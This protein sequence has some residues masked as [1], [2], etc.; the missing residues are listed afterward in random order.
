MLT[1]CVTGRKGNC[2]AKPYRGQARP[3]RPGLPRP[4]D[5]R[6][7]IEARNNTLGWVESDVNYDDNEI[8]GNTTRYTE[9]RPLG[10]GHE[11]RQVPN[12]TDGHR[13]KEAA[14]GI[15]A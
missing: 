12:R 5:D 9:Q 11:L 6:F 4:T 3:A 14:G 10:S 2:Y 13:D 15:R 7:C 8:C 1:F